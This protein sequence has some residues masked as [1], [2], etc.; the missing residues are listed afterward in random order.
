MGHAGSTRLDSVTPVMSHFLHLGRSD[1][2][3]SETHSTIEYNNKIHFQAPN[4]IS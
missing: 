2:L 3:W 1:L 4:R